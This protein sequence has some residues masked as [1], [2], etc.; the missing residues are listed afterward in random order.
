ME[1]RLGIEHLKWGVRRGEASNEREG[2]TEREMG[3]A[4]DKLNLIS[5][6]VLS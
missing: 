5:R 4:E 1:G 6:L 3:D 2:T